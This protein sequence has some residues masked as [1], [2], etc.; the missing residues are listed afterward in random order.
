MRYATQDATTKRSNGSRRLAPGSKGSWAKRWQFFQ[1][2]DYILQKMDGLRPL[3]IWTSYA[4][5][6]TW[7]ACACP[8]EQRRQRLP[9]CALSRWN[10]R[11][12]STKLL[13]DI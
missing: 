2:Q 11:S 12:V 3:L 13:M 5:S 10:S 4:I 8:A 1:R 9:S 6:A 7:A